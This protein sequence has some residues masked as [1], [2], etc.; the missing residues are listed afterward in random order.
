MLLWHALSNYSPPLTEVK[1]RSRVTPVAGEVTSLRQ[2]N[3][4]LDA[5]EVGALVSAYEAGGTVK[6]LAR[7]FEVHHTT[8][9]RL[10]DRAGVIRRKVVPLTEAELSSAARH[11]D[12]G[13]TIAQVGERFDRKY[14]TMRRELLRAGVVMRP[15]LG[16]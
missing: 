12:Q 16:G 3:R 7:E 8:V 14:Q 10:L 15:P 1:K 9:R 2:L 4:R 6:G 5:E 11:Y 13:L